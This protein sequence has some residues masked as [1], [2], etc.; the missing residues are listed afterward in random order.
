MSESEPADGE[1]SGEGT[2]IKTID[3]ELEPELVGY[4]SA[5]KSDSCQNFKSD[6]GMVGDVEKCKNEPTHTM[7]LYSGKYHKIAVCDDCGDP[8]EVADDRKWSGRGTMYAE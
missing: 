6:T 5:V 3:P 1:N 2:P 8:G 4:H 7:V